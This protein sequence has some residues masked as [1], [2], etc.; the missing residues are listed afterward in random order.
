[1]EELFLAKTYQEWLQIATELD[2]IQGRL[3]W[4]EKDHSD[5]FHSQLLRHDLN[6]MRRLRTS[7]QG[8]IL[9]SQLLESLSRHSWELNNQELY[10]YALSGTKYLIS[11][12]LEEVEKSIL[13]ICDNEIDGYSLQ[14][15]LNL[16]TEG[17]RIH[18]QTVIM[19]SGGASFGIYHIG[20]VKALWQQKQL[21]YIISGSSMGAIVAASICTKSDD[22]LDE[23]FTHMDRL[24]KVAI[25]SYPFWDVLKMGSLMDP[26]QLKEHIDHNVED[27]TFWQA[28]RKTG[29]VLNISVSAT[30]KRQKP[31]VLNYLTSPHL[32]IRQSAL[33][34][35]AIPGI[36]APVTLMARNEEGRV[37]PYME[38]EK[39]IDGSVHLDVPMLR[40]M[41]LHNVSRS[42]VS[43]ANPHVLPFVPEK[44]RHGIF[45]RLQDLF[46]SSY[47]TYAIKLMDMALEF[48][49]ALQWITFLEKMRSMIGQQYRGDINISYPL[50]IGDIFRIM[51]NPSDEE[52]YN[53]VHKGELATWPKLAFIR[54]QMKLNIIIESCIEK[55]KNKQ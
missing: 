9:I 15:K 5:L 50:T 14:D 46:M 23:M 55:L 19:L 22:E 35:C 29:R 7:G 39:W 4:R 54:D 51:A 3:D 16:F 31:K 32:L 53:F 11:E 41:R 17:N 48:A 47:Q 27:L 52:F 44:E 28:F 13:Y 38:S 45:A 8:R 33:A 49:D 30:R 10:S 25:K 2:K 1:M 20:V 43:Q 40:I 36:F 34:S 21:P 6:S 42:I 24:H 12:Y 26:A 37:L 18:G